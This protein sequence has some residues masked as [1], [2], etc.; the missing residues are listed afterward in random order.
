L[1][2]L[3]ERICRQEW[4]YCEGSWSW[5]YQKS[6]LSKVLHGWSEIKSHPYQ[7]FLTTISLLWSTPQPWEFK[8]RWEYKKM[9][10]WMI[11][12]DSMDKNQR[13][14][15]SLGSPWTEAIKITFFHLFRS[16]AVPS[17]FS[18]LSTMVRGKSSIVSP[19]DAW[20][21]V[22][23]EEMEITWSIVE[24]SRAVFREKK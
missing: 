20:A 3:Y 12:F 15:V 24:K 17:K 23:L 14:R 10:I 19:I 8:L 18:S 21:V 16:K 13:S 9:K 6:W 1:E 4:G 11:V 2:K 22:L 7:L 5:G